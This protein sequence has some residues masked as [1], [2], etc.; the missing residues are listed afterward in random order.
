[1]GIFPPGPDGRPE[2]KEEEDADEVLG[3]WGRSL[4][5]IGGRTGIM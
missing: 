5:D 4:K 1:M 3:P 2:L